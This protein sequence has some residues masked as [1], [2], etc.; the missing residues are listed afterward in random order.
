[1]TERLRTLSQDGHLALE[2]SDKPL[3]ADDA[4]AGF[5]AREME[6]WYGAHLNHG[7][8]QV[9]RLEGNVGYLD[10][11][12]SRRRRWPPTWRRRP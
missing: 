8:E 10:F 7:F 2:Y 1:M 3:L 4:E 9:A 6:R 5:S 12:C 11:A